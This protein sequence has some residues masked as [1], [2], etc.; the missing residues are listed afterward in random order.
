[1]SANFWPASRAFILHPK[2]RRDRSSPRLVARRVNCASVA[3]TRSG[4]GPRVRPFVPA[5]CRQNYSR[6]PTSSL[7]NSR[8]G[9]QRKSCGTI[10]A[11]NLYLLKIVRII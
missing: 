5:A 10:K 7:F 6:M 1:M 3:N 2:D 4:G 8:L 11:E 9:W